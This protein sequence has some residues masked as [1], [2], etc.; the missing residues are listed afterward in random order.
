MN[1]RIYLNEWFINAGIV[2]FLRILEHNKQDFV[3]KKENY[4]EFDTEDL[5]DFHKYYFNYFFDNYNI[6]KKMEK[7]ISE[8]FGRI[9]NLL[10]NKD[11]KDILKREQK[12]IKDSIKKELKEAIVL[13]NE[14]DAYS[15][16][17]DFGS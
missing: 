8:S 13:D 12:Y 2:G 14:E 1:T 6:A 7:R 11:K 9:E 16:L 10:E 5:K 15:R 4:I 3:K 17:E